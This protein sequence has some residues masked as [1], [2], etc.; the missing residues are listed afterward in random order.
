LLFD[1]LVE[2]PAVTVQSDDP[3]AQRVLKPS[4]RRIELVRLCHGVAKEVGKGHRREVLA[5]VQGQH[6]A[7]STST[8]RDKVFVRLWQQE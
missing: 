8:D 1:Q 6:G 4:Q 2:P 3:L 7:I 5:E